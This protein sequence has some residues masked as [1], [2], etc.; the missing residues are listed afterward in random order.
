MDQEYLLEILKKYRQG[1]TTDEE[2][3]FLLQSYDAFD[4]QPDI[5]PMLTSGER[6]QL[7]HRIHTGILEQITPV[8]A[9]HH[10]IIPWRRIAAAVLL[11]TGLAG[12]AFILFQQKKPLPATIAS[13]TIVRPENEN[14]LIALPD[15][16]SVLVSAGSSLQYPPSFEGLPRR[17]VYLQGK[18]LFTVEQ[19]HSQPFIVNAGGL[20][21]TVLGTTF[22][23]AT[24]QTGE[25][26]VTVTRGRVRVN[27]KRRSLGELSANEQM[28][29]DS[30][31]GDA[32]HLQLPSLAPPAWQQEDML[33]D[34]VTLKQAAQ[35]LED[36]FHVTIAIANEQL[37]QQRFSTIVLKKESLSQI[38][39]SICTFH[40]AG[41]TLDSIKRSVIIYKP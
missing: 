29:Y 34:D 35:L 40:K 8:P 38:L 5:T 9:V 31:E 12:T 24:Q 10:R 14:N 26:K 3:Q 36:R 7:K 13:Q 20:Q 28:V 37:R 33:F 16:S 18:A 6:E 39:H 23:V 1:I 19:R 22:E 11:V 32:Q 27:D 17:E 30:R 15:G 2:A 4:A 41:Y 25:V 21:T